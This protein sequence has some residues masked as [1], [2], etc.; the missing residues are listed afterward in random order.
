[1][2]FSAVT[3]CAFLVGLFVGAPAFSN[4]DV[5]TQHNDPART[6][7]QLSES[8]LR[9]S[10]VTPSTFGRLYERYVDGQVI[11]QPLYVSGLTIPGQGVR[12]VVYVATRKNLIYAFDADNL[13]PDPTHGLIWSQPVQVEAP[14]TVPGLARGQCSETLGDVGINSTPVIDRA[15]ATMYVVARKVDGTLWLHALD[16]VTGQP[17]AGTP[18]AVQ[19]AAAVTVGGQHIVFD[20]TLELSR[21]ALL[22]QNGA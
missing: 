15:S 2:R 22:F 19:I 7:A 1:M 14:G 17:K 16:I 11:A 9:P 21:A 6:G 12:N 8:S 10:N 5:L 18:G 3:F 13:D 4:S 20:Q